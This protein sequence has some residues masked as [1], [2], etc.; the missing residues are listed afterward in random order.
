MAPLVSVIVLTYRTPEYAVKCV[1]ALLAQTILRLRSRSGPEALQGRMAG[2]VADRMEVIVVDNHSEDDSIGVLRNRLRHFPQVRVV[3][4]AV[5]RGYGRGNNFGASFARGEY[6][7]I[8]NPDNELP[9]DAVERFVR[10]L[11]AD[12][13]IGILAPALVFGDGSV[14]D[15]ARA[16]PT[17]FDV[18]VKRTALRRLFPRRMRRYLR[19]DAP[20][21]ALA[22]VDWVVGACLF[23]RLD[24]FRQLGGF[25]ERFF[26]FFE[27]MDLCRRCRIAGKR[28][29][30]ASSIVARDRKDRLSGEGVLSLLWKRTGRAHIASALRYFW[31]WKFEPSPHMC[32]ATEGHG[33]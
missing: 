29:V 2:Q 15:S 5:N 1:Q 6:L 10:I 25:D 14:R 23:L 3:E 12:P 31:K 27:D 13:T 22:D 17:L 8:I 33:S 16:F 26:L 9:P 20:P 18:L 7:L 30:Y 4:S 19:A 21:A 24:F 32:G 11:E 28:V